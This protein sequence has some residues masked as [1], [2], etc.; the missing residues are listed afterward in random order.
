MYDSDFN[1]DDASLWLNQ[2]KWLYVFWN[3]PRFDYQFKY[4]R[5]NIA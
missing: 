2:I 4:L 5:I 1:E 3:N